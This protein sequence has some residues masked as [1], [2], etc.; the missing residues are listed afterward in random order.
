MLFV[1][2]TM[3]V[4]V[5]RLLNSLQANLRLPPTVYAR[6]LFPVEF[7][8]IEEKLAHILALRNR[9]ATSV[10]FIFY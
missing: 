10:V 7:V 2:R 5:R 6:E 9:N 1:L 4:F 8:C 3:S